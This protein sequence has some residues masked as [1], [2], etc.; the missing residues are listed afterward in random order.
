LLSEVALVRSL[1]SPP[2]VTTTVVSRELGAGTMDLWVLP[3]ADLDATRL[4]V[5]VLDSEERRRVAT[6][7]RVDQHWRYVATHLRL[8]Q[9]LGS[10][11]GLAPAAVSFWRQPCP[12]C[13]A[14]HGRP[15][16]HS[17]ARPLYFSLSRSR[18]LALI[19]IAPAP[20]GVDVEAL[21]QPQTVSEVSALL[22]PAEQAEIASASVSQRA[23]AFACVWTRKEAYLKAI[24]VGVTHEL[25]ADYLGT[26]GR[27]AGPPGWTLIAAPVAA[28]YRG[29]VAVQGDLSLAVHQA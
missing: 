7:E 12:C 9:L 20:V 5:S 2:A 8:R 10:Y 17:H 16:V 11:L 28:G 4:D 26:E 21:P 18:D 15:A 19:A 13:A 6:L 14:A 22:H 3:L 24:G 29:A 1:P 25:A 23:G 27:V